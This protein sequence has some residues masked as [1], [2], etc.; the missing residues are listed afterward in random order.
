MQKKLDLLLAIYITSLVAAELLGSKIT[1]I[2]GA[3]ISVGIVAFPLTF[4]IN[5]IVTEVAGKERARHFVRTGLLMLAILFGMV[6]IARA[7]PPAGFYSHNEA[8]ETVFSNSLRIIVA[9]LSAFVVSELLDIT[10]FNKIKERMK[11]FLWFR[12]NISNIVSQF[13]DTTVFTFIA[14]YMVTSA[15]DFN[16]MVALILPYWGLK[17]LF[18]F[19]QTPLAYVGVYWLNRGEKNS[20]TR[21][22]PS[23]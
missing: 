18:S 4:L 11:R 13:I 15:Y 9:S 1:T 6:L 2:L 17:I 10:I 5:D 21:Q 22:K 20:L 16:K 8:Y 19:V 23:T 12:V 14:F 7:L 3:N